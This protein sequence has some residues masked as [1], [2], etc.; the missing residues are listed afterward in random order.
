MK[1]LRRMLVAAS[2]LSAVGATYVA[3]TSE[4]GNCV[5][6]CCFYDDFYWCGYL[7]GG[8]RCPE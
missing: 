1:M 2:L 3:K 7:C 4:A 8:A 6:T 5:Y